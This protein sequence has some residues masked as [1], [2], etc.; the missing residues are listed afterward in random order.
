MKWLREGINLVEAIPPTFWGIVFG[1]FFSLGGVI[2]TNRAND[3]RLT[4]QLN[5]DREVRGKERDLTLRK[6]IYLGAVEGLQAGVEMIAGFSNLEIPYVKLSEGYQ[7]RAPAV[8][9][10]HVIAKKKHS[11]R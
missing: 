1:S 10:V 8:A 4:A 2:I 3:R 7:E 5:H 6:E 9:K 11:R